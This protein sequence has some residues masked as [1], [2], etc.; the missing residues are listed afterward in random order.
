MF[1]KNRGA[2]TRKNPHIVRNERLEIPRE[3]YKL[4]KFVTLT[5]DVIFVCGLPFLITFSRNI[6]MT[7]AEFT[8]NRTAGRLAKSIKKIVKLYARGGFIVNLALMDIEFEKISDLV[9]FLEVNTMAA[10]KHVGDV[11]R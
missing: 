10:R 2:T 1:A 8:P 4:N 3:F 9:G 11:E 5:A 7:T 6:K